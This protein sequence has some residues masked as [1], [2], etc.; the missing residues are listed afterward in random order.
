MSDVSDLEALRAENARLRSEN[1]RLRRRL[2]R[3]MYHRVQVALPALWWAFW[4]FMLVKVL[5]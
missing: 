1:H 2:Q 5:F 4:L 3:R